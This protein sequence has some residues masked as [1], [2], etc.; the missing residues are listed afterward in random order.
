MTIT[1]SNYS[2]AAANYST[3]SAPLPSPSSSQP[4]NNYFSTHRHRSSTS[5]PQT[6]TQGPTREPQSQQPFAPSQQAQ[7]QQYGHVPYATG[8]EEDFC[9]IA[10]AAKRAQMA[11][12]MRDMGEVAL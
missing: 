12:L 7:G 3:S 10:E 8:K 11:V 1:D 5:I 2:A 4:S 6:H 9:L